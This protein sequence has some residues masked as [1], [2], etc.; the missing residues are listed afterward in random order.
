MKV[1][2]GTKNIRDLLLSPLAKILSLGDNSLLANY[3]RRSEVA[4]SS[5]TTSF[6]RSK[7]QRT[8]GPEHAGNTALKPGLDL[9]EVTL[10][11]EACSVEGAA[12]PDL[13]NSGIGCWL[14][15]EDDVREHT[16]Y[17]NPVDVTFILEQE[18]PLL[19]PEFLAAAHQQ[20]KDAPAPYHIWLFFFWEGF[21][22]RFDQ[23][24]GTEIRWSRDDKNV[25]PRHPWNRRAGLPEG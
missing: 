15:E 4:D 6:G 17:P 10:G 21:L 8:Q 24:R 11:T 7:R 5:I 12:E 3:F 18:D 16:P 13:D 20:E 9:D 2:S 22:S 14:T 19:I 23:V 25:Y 1:E